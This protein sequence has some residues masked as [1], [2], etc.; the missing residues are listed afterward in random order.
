MLVFVSLGCID[1]DC[2]GFTCRFFDSTF[3]LLLAGLDMWYCCIVFADY[4]CRLEA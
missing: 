2:G 4:V 3:V 1:F